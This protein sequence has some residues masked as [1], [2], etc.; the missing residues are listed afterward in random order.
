MAEDTRGIDWAKRIQAIAQAGLAYSRDAFDLERFEEL[1]S[2]S[3]EMMAAYSG[4]DIRQ[5]NHLF[6]GESGYATPKVD[7]RGVVIRDGKILL[8]QEKNDGGWS[9]PGGWAD[10][11]L[12]PREIVVKEVKEESG[13]DV[14]PVRLLA[15]LDRNK[16]P[17]P[18]HAYDIYKIFIQCELTGGQARASIETSDVGFFAPDDLPQL[19]TDRITESQIELLFRQ[20]REP[21]EAVFD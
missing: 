13:Y 12:S 11:G 16:H 21:G 3:V 9:L 15:V 7:I 20:V 5:V 8:V 19:S 6:A 18:P 10:I 2:I 17:H 14:A 1:R 4:L